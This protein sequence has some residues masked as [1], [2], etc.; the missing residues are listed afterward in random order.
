MFVFVLEYL[1]E[2][3]V[4]VQLGGDGDYEVQQ[5]LEQV[6]GVVVVVLYVQF[7]DLYVQGLVVVGLEF[8]EEVEQ[9]EYQ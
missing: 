7:L 9:G 4:E 2:V 3:E 6:D 8:G 1:E 5:C